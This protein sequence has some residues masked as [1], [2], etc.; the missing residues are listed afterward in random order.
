[1]GLLATLLLSAAGMLASLF[2]LPDAPNFSFVKMVIAVLIF[3]LI[4]LAAALRPMV[5]RT[6][7]GP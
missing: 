1:M 2:L 6:R 7:K 5:R 3:T 4:V